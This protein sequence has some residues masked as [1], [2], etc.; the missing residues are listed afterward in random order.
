MQRR[1][2]T[3]IFLNAR[4]N[5]GHNTLYKQT[6]IQYLQACLY[7]V[8]HLQWA[9]RGCRSCSTPSNFPPHITTVSKDRQYEDDEETWLVYIS[10]NEKTEFGED[11]PRDARFC[12]WLPRLERI[13][14]PPATSSS[15]SS[16][17]SPATQGCSR[18]SRIVHRSIGSWASMS[19]SRETTPLEIDR[20]QS[21]SSSSSRP[22]WM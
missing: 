16:S 4:S 8:I 5:S 22:H 6:T 19:E 18:T 11:G 10:S 17:S 1:H 2:A 14:M 3:F 12:C 7:N 9:E 20:P 13:A 15:S 21:C